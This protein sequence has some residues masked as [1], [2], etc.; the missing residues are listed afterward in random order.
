MKTPH[1]VLVIDDE[2]IICDSCERIL[3]NED[4][5]VDTLTNPVEGYQKALTN[6]YDLVLLDL[7]MAGMDGMQLL[8]KL[9]KDKPELPVIIITGYPTKETK[10]IAK[11]L[12]VNYYVLKPFMP[13]EILDPVKRIMHRLGLD[14][15]KDSITNQQPA[16]SSDWRSGEKNYMFYMNGWLQK[17]T[18]SHVRVGGQ[19]PVFIND[20]ITSIKTVGVKEKIFQGFPL[21]EISFENDIKISIPSPVSG[22]VMNLNTELFG[23][24][25]L[26]DKDG[27]ND[28]WIAEVMPDKM[29]D[30]IAMCDVRKVILFSNNEEGGGEYLSKIEN[31]GY[32]TKKVT[33][34]EDVI[35]SLSL[36][37]GGATVDG[38]V[39]I[40]DAKSFGDQGPQ[41]VDTIKSKDKETKIIVFNTTDSK[42]E[43]LYR[44]KKIFYYAVDP[45][46]NREIASMLYG[47]FCFSKDKEQIENKQTTFLP[48]TISRIGI[49]NRHSKKVVLL[50]YDNVIKCNKGA[51]YLLIQSLLENAYPIDIVHSKSIKKAKD[52]SCVQSIAE[53]QLKNDKII[54]LSKDNLGKIPGSISI[55][56]EN[57]E[58]SGGNENILARIAIQP[59][60]FDSDEISF[61][62]NTTKALAEFIEFEMTSM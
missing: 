59:S 1:S 6:N 27:K 34:V 5:K 56:V 21:A 43:T 42:L 41:F 10:E 55:S 9:K 40:I 36:S 25:S 28:N 26:L 17:G 31:L 24:P 33:S 39:V 37:E 23:N 20:A 58:N 38:K 2:Q 44:E 47:V 49:T 7:N 11:S 19:L 14:E 62:L 22:E 51:G 48:Q 13:S 8:S 12:G 60:N 61:D 53:E 15:K 52:P 57:Y 3:S 29:E 32:I 30:D 35:T 16:K 45:I 46:S 4:Y 18:D 54:V 50:A